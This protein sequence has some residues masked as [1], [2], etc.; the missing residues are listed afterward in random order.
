L[1]T[2][3][4]ND[5][6]KLSKTTFVNIDELIIYLLSITNSTLEYEDFS[7]KETEM[8]NNL[9]S[10]NDFKNTVKNLKI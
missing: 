1:A 3:T 10:F 9:K 7:S 4:L 2:I 5:N 8:I 6:T